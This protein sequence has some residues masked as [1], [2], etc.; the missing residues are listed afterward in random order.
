MPA[1]EVRK[2]PA[3]SRGIGSI[4]SEKPYASAAP[5][6]Q[7]PIRPAA[8][9]SVA[10]NPYPSPV[11]MPKAHTATAAVQTAATPKPAARQPAVSRRKALADRTAA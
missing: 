7:R 6:T 10:S 2:T 1:V 8:I 5:H 11:G 3:N 9:S 4:S